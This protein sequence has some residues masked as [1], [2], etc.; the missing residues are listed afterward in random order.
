MRSIKNF[1]F[2]QLLFAGLGLTITTIVFASVRSSLDVPT[3]P[4]QPM[5]SNI[6]SGRCDLK[7]TKPV[8]NGGAPIMRYIVESR[9]AVTGRWVR[10][11]T[12]PDLYC[13]IDNMQTG[14]QVVFRVKAVNRIGVSEPSEN[15]R[16]IM[17]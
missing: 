1:F 7:Y 5:V 2:K 8:D 10:K 17:F 3:P 4:G 13:S 16:P 15:S 9:S 6:Q 11:A 12:V 14:I